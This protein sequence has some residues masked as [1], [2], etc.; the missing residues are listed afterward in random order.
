MPKL[1]LYLSYLRKKASDL[2]NLP[3][4]ISLMELMRGIIYWVLEI[5]MENYQDPFKCEGFPNKF[6]Q[7][8]L[9]ETRM[10]DLLIDCLVYPFETGLFAYDDLTLQHPITRIC[11]LVYRILKHTVKECNINKNYVAQWIDLFF[12]QAMV[13]TEKNSFLAEKTI[14]ELLLN[15]KQLLDTQIETSTIVS[16]IELCLRQPKHERFLNL[17]SNLCQ[18]EGQAITS[19][20]DGIYA[21]VLENL[22]NRKGMLVP[23][24]TRNRVHY[25]HIL[26]NGVAS[27]T[28]LKIPI[29]ELYAYFVEKKDLRLYNY[30]QSLIDLMAS[31][32]MERNYKSINQ[33]VHIYTLD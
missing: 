27:S 3:F 4:F 13:T 23:I 30:F 16:L 17:L 20:Q 7:K 21:T 5:D 28:L 29:E 32:C 15:N 19:N 11:Q 8:I 6:R 31:I 14:T 9:R 26:D 12:K 22:Q 25:V 1:K 10:I 2:L 24:E 33:L 18:C